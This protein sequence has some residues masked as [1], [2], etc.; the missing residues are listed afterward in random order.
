MKKE[1]MIEQKLEELRKATEGTGCKLIIMTANEDSHK[2]TVLLNG[3]AMDL[4]NMMASLLEKNRHR[5]RVQPG[6]IAPRPFDGR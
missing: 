5:Y 2:A 4:V 3:N 6:R 1:D